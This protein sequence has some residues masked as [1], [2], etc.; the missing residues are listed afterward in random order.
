MIT[1][2]QVSQLRY[3]DSIPLDLDN[4]LLIVA[5]TGVI[6]VNVFSIVGTQFSDHPDRTLLL[7]NSLIGLLQGV[8]QTV[9]V[10]GS[11]K[12]QLYTRRQEQMK[13]GREVVTFLMVT[14]FAMVR[15]K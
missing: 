14:N 12:R 4:I 1:F 15:I 2:L 6:S 7:F 8:A 13:P 5:L 11:S 9:F 10:L 3:D